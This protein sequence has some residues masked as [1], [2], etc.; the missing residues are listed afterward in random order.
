MQENYRKD[1]NYERAKNEKFDAAV[2][3]IMSRIQKYPYYLFDGK[4]IEMNKQIFGMLT[5]YQI[6]LF[7]KNY[8][9]MT[10]LEDLYLQERQVSRI[11]A[12][13]S[14]ML[15]TDPDNV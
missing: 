9:T 6:M 4:T 8:D 12:H 11:R 10:N 15:P 3:L 14:S 7:V 5:T 13:L 1:M 2:E